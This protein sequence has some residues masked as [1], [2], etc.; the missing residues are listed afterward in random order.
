MRIF[1]GASSN[2]NMPE[3]Y[4]E[5]CKKL[6]EVILK[7]NDL[8]FGAYHNGL[9]GISYDIAKKNKRK[10]IGLCPLFYKDRLDALECDHSEV[11]TTVL[12]S[13]LKMYKNT[14]YA[15]TNSSLCV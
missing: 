14:D 10:V 6:L 2:E 13:T 15:L 8:V 9:M 1:V 7:D 4:V 3:K 11:T 12:D 5:D